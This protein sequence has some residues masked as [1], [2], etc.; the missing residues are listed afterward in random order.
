[1]NSS[2]VNFEGKPII[3]DG[4]IFIYFD[5]QTGKIYDCRFP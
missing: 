3:E 1:M 4:D 2:A 5:P